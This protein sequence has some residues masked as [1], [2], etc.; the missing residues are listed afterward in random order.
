MQSVSIAVELRKIKGVALRLPACGH[1]LSHLR[2]VSRPALDPNRGLTISVLSPSVPSREASF[3]PTTPSEESKE[4]KPK[5]PALSSRTG[6][7]SCK[8]RG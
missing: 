8:N 1:P 4:S 5:P 3:D 2:F 7:L 6:P